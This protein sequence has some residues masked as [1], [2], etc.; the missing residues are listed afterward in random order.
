MALPP[1]AGQTDLHRLT[2]R[3]LAVLGGGF[4]P[5]ALAG[6]HLAGLIF[7][8]NPGLPFA[9]GPV[10][11]GVA[12]YGTLLGLVSL[13]L[14]L[15]FTR[16]H[17]RR[18]LRALPWG[19]T[20]ALAIAALLDWTHASYFAYYLPPGINDRLIKTALWL[21][22]GALIAFYTALLH[23]LHRRR[24]GRRS[25]WGLTLMALLSIYAMVE[26]REAFH[27]RPAPAPRPAAV[28]S[29]RRPRLWVIGVDSATLDAI[30]PL[31]GQGRLPFLASVLQNGAYGRLESLSPARR[32]ALWTTLATGKYPF[33][34]GVTGQRPYPAGFLAAGAELRLLPTGLSFRRWGTL[35]G[36]PLPPPSHPRQTLALWEILPRLG[37]PAGVAGWPAA[38][39]THGEAVF[40]LADRYFQPAPEPGSAWPVDLFDRGLLFRPNARDLE[41]SLLGRFGP[42]PSRS[43]FAAL[44]GDAW[45]EALTLSLADQSPRVE[46]VFLVL[47]G[48][49]EVSRDAFGGFSRVQFDGEKGGAARAAADRVTAYYVQLDAF[50]AEVWAHGE[51]PR[52]LAVVSAYGASPK[53]AG[54]PRLWQGVAPAAAL[55]GSFSDA[56]DGVLLLY[57]EGIRPAALVTGA[58][59]ED[60]APT[61]LYG[62]GFPVAR[63]LD[64]QVLTSAFDKRFLARNPLTFFPSYE[65]LAPAGERP[66]RRD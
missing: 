37:V 43:L 50:L 26:R 35:G 24:Y 41:A 46:A 42:R 54:W 8:L 44:A 7:F 65:G 32:D 53:G 17:P 36:G 33:K 45:R 62:L 58:Q 20:A 25:R 63:D 23:S 30:L 59:L 18:A 27:P 2:R 22:L 4:A 49:R 60:V 56:P 48:L 13:A 3:W 21:S 1:E 51:G 55:G 52:L 47:P 6:I 31:A 14:H 29:G 66:A 57:G 40:A 19:L 5:G 11:R 39:P 12:V 64:G 34:H 16:R 38:E 9:V 10:L 61:L 28:E 15:P